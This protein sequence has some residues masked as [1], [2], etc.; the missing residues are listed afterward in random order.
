MP[1]IS[2]ISLKQQDTVQILAALK[3]FPF[4]D[5]CPFEL[6]YLAKGEAIEAPSPKL[7]LF[8]ALSIEELDERES[9]LQNTLIFSSLASFEAYSAQKKLYSPTLYVHPDLAILETNHLV[10]LP[11]QCAL[12]G[13]EAQKLLLK[14][15]E[16]TTYTDMLDYIKHRK[17][18]ELLVTSNHNLVL[19]L[20][21][22][23]K[24][25]WA[26]SHP[27]LNANNLALELWDE[28]FSHIQ[29]TLNHVQKQ[30]CD[31][32]PL[33]DTLYDIAGIR[34]AHASDKHAYSFFAQHYDE[35][36][37]H[38][39]YDQWVTKLLSWIKQYTD[40]PLKRVLEL[41][42]GTANVANRFVL[43]GLH[44][45]ACDIS[46][47][48][49]HV[50]DRKPLKPNLYQAS[51]TDPIPGRNYELV[52][53]MF[54]SVNYLTKSAEISKMLEQVYV[55]LADK[56]LFIFDI[57]T[58]FNSEENFADICSLSHHKEGYLV[59]Q[60]WFDPVKNR[61][62]SG[63]TSF[64]KD[65][66]SYNYQYELH[67]QRVYLCTDLISLIHKSPLKLKAIHSTES[68]T[69]YYPRHINGIDDRYS[70]LFF[71]LR[72]ESV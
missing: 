37:A 38:V 44:V 66:I 47:D 55:A 6:H 4:R 32:T 22:I 26:I 29:Y 15:T 42:C 31:T 52:L 9:G 72:K 1:S 21:S 51:L 27:E 56:G 58:L 40:I 17:P 71:I 48:M 53:C 49:L 13:D 43:Q 39:V 25:N 35:Y 63:L 8:P 30:L 33:P 12:Q 28:P 67:H 65:F 2:I 54:D 20:I 64:R 69:N 46:A 24:V 36:M 7:V 59:H 70:R 62:N 14:N 41:A 18:E 61:Q 50:A 57:S 10:Q 60:A 19:T 68:K 23:D 3:F 11:E 16:I 5:N 34:N 45:D